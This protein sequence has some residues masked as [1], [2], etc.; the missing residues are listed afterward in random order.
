MPEC[1]S[2]WP[3]KIAGWFVLATVSASLAAQQNPTT[4]PKIGTVDARFQSY[5]IEMVEVIGGRFWKPY[6]SKAPADTKADSGIGL[7]PSLYEQRGS[8]NLSDPRLRKL[9]K[10]LGPAYLRVSGSWA[11]TVYFQDLDA[12]APAKPPDGFGSVLTRA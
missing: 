2:D 1:Y 10:A 3:M 11:N 9:A 5:N 7:D 8:V 12:P 4:M 6:G